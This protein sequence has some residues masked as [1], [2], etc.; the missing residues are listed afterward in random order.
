MADTSAVRHPPNRGPHYLEHQTT[1]QDLSD[2]LLKELLTFS[3]APGR[4]WLCLSGK[5][6]CTV[7]FCV[8]NR[9]LKQLIRQDDYPMSLTDDA[10]ETI[11]RALYFFFSLFK[12][13]I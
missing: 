1:D 9:K 11:Q 13:R 10:L 7:R 2:I 3:Y 8:G 4:R 12:Q 5:N 6:D